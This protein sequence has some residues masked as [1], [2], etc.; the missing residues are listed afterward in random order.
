MLHLDQIHCGYGRVSI[1]KGVTLHVAPGE[2]LGLLGRN[3]AGK[4]TTLKLIMGLLRASAGRVRLDDQELT[5][6]AAHRIP[7]LGIGYVPQGRGLFG[8]FTV[9]ENLLMGLLVRAHGATTLAR[10]LD[11]FPVLQERLNQPAGTLSGGEQQMLAMAHALC[12]EP[13]LLL[14]D[15]PTEGLMPSAVDRLLDTLD[16]LKAQRIAV[17][18]VE[19]KIDA[20]LR[21]ADRI[22]FIEN[23]AVRAHSDPATLATDPAPL[24]RYLGVSG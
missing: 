1:L 18:L 19:Q 23:G 2:V 11:L 3:G 21:A 4:T 12:I 16:T 7:R 9:R 10:V 17:L 5:H 6:L 13:K 8:S 22:D 14:L 20:A 15:E 24:D